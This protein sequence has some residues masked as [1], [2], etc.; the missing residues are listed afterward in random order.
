MACAEGGLYL[1]SP[2]VGRILD[3]YKND[4]K[5]DSYEPSEDPGVKSVTEIYN[6]FR[7]FGYETVVMGASFRNIAEIIELAGCDKLT[8]SPKL[9]EE[10]EA[11]QQL[12]PLKLDAKK[13]EELDIQEITINEGTFRYEMNKSKM[14]TDLLSAGIRKFEE[15]GD[16]LKNMIRAAIDKHFKKAE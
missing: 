16:K 14:A 6:Y 12:V 7:K 3:W 11:S 5:K 15:D 10:L 9:L 13:A 8:I 4:Q 1:I 2:F